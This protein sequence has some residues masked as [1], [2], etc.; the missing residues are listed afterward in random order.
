MKKKDK[1]VLA[2]ERFT[3]TSEDGKKKLGIKVC[4]GGNNSML[5]VHLDGYGDCCSA[6]G[7]GEVMAID[8]FEGRPRI[9]V[10]DDI[11]IEDPQII[12]LEFALE[13]NR[14]VNKNGVPE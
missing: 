6:D 11:N 13:S 10:W 7:K 1:A 5:F 3:L 9:L 12:D 4:K 8:F 14:A 2:S